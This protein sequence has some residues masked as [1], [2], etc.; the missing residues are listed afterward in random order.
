MPGNQQLDMNKIAYA[1]ALALCLAVTGTRAQQHY[2]VPDESQGKNL[3]KLNLTNLLFKSFTVQYDRALAPGKTVGVSV[4]FRPKTDGPMAGMYDAAYEEIPNGPNYAMSTLQTGYLSITPNIRFFVKRK[5]PRGFYIETYL[6]YENMSRDYDFRSYD[7][8]GAVTAPFVRGT[9][10]SQTQ[11]FGVGGMIGYQVLLGR[12]MTLDFWFVG[13][14]LGYSH[15]KTTG[16]SHNA[17]LTP[18]DQAEIQTDISSLTNN[19]ELQWIGS[20]FT[21]TKSG[22]GMDVRMLGVNLGIVF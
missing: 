17:T 5:A 14:H 11:F 15:T 22:A 19:A 21:G 20:G 2:F 16:D 8:S 7:F 3:V 9:A 13:T 12:K 6:R 10:T 4:N 1:A 18:A